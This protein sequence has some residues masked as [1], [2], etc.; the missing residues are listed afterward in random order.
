MFR[1]TGASF[2]FKKTKF[3][4]TKLNP[5][6]VVFL[7]L[8]LSHEIVK[9]E[10]KKLLLPVLGGFQVSKN[11]LSLLHN[12]F[13][14]KNYSKNIFQII[15]FQSLFYW[16]PYSMRISTVWVCPDIPE[17]RSPSQE[18]EYFSGWG[19]WQPWLLPCPSQMCWQTWVWCPLSPHSAPHSALH[20]PQHLDL[21]PFRCLGS[22]PWL[23]LEAG[24]HCHQR[25][26]PVW[27]GSGTQP[28][29]MDLGNRA[30][31][32]WPCSFTPVLQLLW[33]FNDS[34]YAGLREQNRAH[35]PGLL[36]GSNE[37]MPVKFLARVWHPERAQ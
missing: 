6:N 22:A 7:Y 23:C 2:S 10:K 9:K 35:L 29:R 24:T 12:I 28:P 1:L 30:M 17:P 4:W 25:G 32:P 14:W 18:P 3:V 5:R 36:A 15:A 16:F 19:I 11:L 20:S 37:M 27:R 13:L 26:S 34:S 33:G 21:V 31:Q 8:S